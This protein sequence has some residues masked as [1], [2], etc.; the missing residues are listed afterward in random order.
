MEINGYAEI[1]PEKLTEM[2]E[3]IIKAV[4]KKREEEKASTIKW[5]R[6]EVAKATWWGF[7]SGRKISKKQAL[8]ELKEIS[9]DSTFGFGCRWTYIHSK[10][11]D[12]AEEYIAACNNVEEDKTI[13]VKTS[14]FNTYESWRMYDLTD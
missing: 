4:N 5:H 3:L 8:E 9:R 6:K 2:C 1:S 14:F 12:L 13:I 10:A 7:K 11:I